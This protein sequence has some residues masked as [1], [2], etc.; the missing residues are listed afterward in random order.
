[1]AYDC[2]AVELSTEFVACYRDGTYPGKSLNFN[3]TF[4]KPGKSWE[5][6]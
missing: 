2:I 4:S 3:I 5:L 6:V 1:M